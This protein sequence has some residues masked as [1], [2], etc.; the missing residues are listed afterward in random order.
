VDVVDGTPLRLNYDSH[1]GYPFSSVSRVLIERKLIPREAVSPQRIGAWM[2][3]HT[4]EAAKV[5]AANRS[6]VFFRITGLTNEGEPVG[7]LGEQL[8][9]DA[10]SPSTGA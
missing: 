5:R 9:R 6:Y 10:P 3:A 8:T 7:A 4:D 1:N 2:A